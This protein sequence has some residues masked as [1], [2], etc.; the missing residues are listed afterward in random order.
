MIVAIAIC[1]VTAVA[2]IVYIAAW[3]FPARIDDS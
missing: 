1:A 3:L 2:A